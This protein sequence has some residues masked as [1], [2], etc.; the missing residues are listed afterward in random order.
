M[1]EARKF[2]PLPGDN[3]ISDD[4]DDILERA[5]VAN[6]FVRKVLE[7]DT[8]HGTA[9]GVFAPWGSGKTSFVNLARKTF[10]CKGVRVLDFNP[11][12]F[13]GAEQLVER[14]FAELSV[15]LKQHDL[16]AVGKALEGY[17]DAF[18]G[19]SGKAGTVE[20]V[21]ALGVGVLGAMA[22]GG[23]LS[24]LSGEVGI[25]EAVVAVA[26]GFIVLGA[27]MKVVGKG[28]QRR[29]GGISSRRKKVA[30]TLRKHGKPIVVVLDDVDRLSAP[31]IRE[32]FKLVRLTASFPNL[33]Y[34]VSCD[35][36]RVEQAL[37]ERG[38][39]LSGRDYLEK[40]IQWSFNLPE[41][42]SHLL[43]QQLYKSIENAL[44]DI[45]NPG[46]FR[47]EVWADIR[48]E[49]VRPLIRNMR[50]VRRYAI[51]IRATVDGLDGQVARAD[52][53][54]LEAIRV[55]L[56]D[57]FRLLPSAID[58][59]TGMTQ[60]VDRPVDRM[61]LQVP[62]N[63][64]SGYNE[65]LKTQVD[66]LIAAAEKDREPEA[67]RT[68]R[69]VVEA[70]VDHLFPVGTRL[71][72]LSDGD[73]A[74]FAN[75]DAAEHLRERRVAH[76]HVLRLYL[77]RVASPDLLALHDAD[78]ALARMTDRDGL[79]KFIRSLEPTRWQDVVSNLC[80]LADPFGP[81][82]VEPGVVVLLNLWPDMPERPSSSSVLGD[83][84]RGTVRRATLRLLRVLDDAATVETTVR[85]IL[86]QLT[87]LSSKVELVLQVGHRKNSGHKLVSETAV[88]EFE[89]ILRHKIR[90]TSADELANE[91]DPSRIL[92]FGKDYGW[93]TEEPF[94]IDI[95]PQ[96]TFSLLRS[97]RGEMQ[98][99]SIGSRAVSR[100]AVLDWDRLIDLYGSKEVLETRINELKSGFDTLKPWIEARRIPL[101][102]AEQLLE[103]AE[104]YLSG[105]RPEAD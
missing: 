57:V 86:P 23:A 97:V 87:S 27:T 93:P 75:D 73:S 55:F 82:H 88:Y 54:A 14:F 31:E 84:A 16:E 30:S 11:W 71:R 85:H 72:N 65:R 46:P 67:A 104:R 78:R 39:G 19:L 6:A 25:V 68:A 32:V 37:D 47:E 33:I 69:E 7:L 79:N 40:I 64:L 94:E 89:N 1:N 44:A 81:E 95:S 34:I 59:L 43:A 18:Y 101:D 100:S 66:G 8:R 28:L 60:A 17:G 50:D 29:Q 12:L 36:L 26:V 98:T 62:D 35:R 103:L 63:P 61:P 74:P 22:S 2:T 96:L 102:E 91:R 41:V 5:D 56:P 24:E 45:K 90:A 21:V 15:E 10:E 38:Q 58:G 51:A 70:M 9:V 77:E 4:G 76:E 52:V 20:L 53:L 92:V 42:P 99:G 49:I 13:S 48:A 83:D 105:W 3:P 80:G